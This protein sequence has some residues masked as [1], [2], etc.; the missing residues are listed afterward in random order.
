MNLVYEPYA[1]PKYYYKEFILP[2]LTITVSTYAV[3]QL[4]ST[5]AV[6]DLVYEPYIYG[7][8]IYI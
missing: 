2:D 1:V 8:C 6:V 7:P 3:V 4:W 5:Y